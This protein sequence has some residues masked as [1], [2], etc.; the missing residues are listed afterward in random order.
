[1][2]WRVKR[3]GESSSSGK[4]YVQVWLGCTGSTSLNKKQVSAT[5]NHLVTRKGW[6]MSVW[7]N[8]SITIHILN[9]EKVNDSKPHN[10]TPYCHTFTV[11]SPQHNFTW[12]YKTQKM[13]WYF[14]NVPW[15]MNVAFVCF[16]KKFCLHTCIVEIHLVQCCCIFCTKGK[17][18]T[19]KPFSDTFIA[20][21]W[22]FH[23]TIDTT[24]L[25]TSKLCILCIC[26]HRHTDIF[27]ATLHWAIEY[28]ERENVMK[29][30][31]AYKM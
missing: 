1:M 28:P 27:Q 31:Q 4:A 22:P 15:Q 23:P 3:I 25:K 12:S 9:K 29:C 11:K 24:L 30:G 17:N 13:C 14:I 7:Y 2:I 8:H 16:G 20:L 5:K 21:L 6:H 19:T 26:T 10:G 18:V